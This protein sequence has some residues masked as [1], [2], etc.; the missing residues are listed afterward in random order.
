MS[1]CPPEG[2]SLTPAQVAALIAANPCL[3]LP[4]L[5]AAY[6]DAI[7]G[8]K[9]SHVSFKDRSTQYQAASPVFL[10]REIQRLERMCPGP[11]NPT[12]NARAAVARGPSRGFGFRYW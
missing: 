12:P 6:Y 10:Q 11:N 3:A 7:S 2:P 5:Y 4:R 8:T 9:R 1:T